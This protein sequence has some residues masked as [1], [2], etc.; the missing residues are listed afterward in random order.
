MFD[1]QIVE[2][3]FSRYDHY[4]LD[5]DCKNQVYLV[6]QSVKSHVYKFSML[7]GCDVHACVQW[8]NISDNLPRLTSISDALED[9][10][11]ALIHMIIRQCTNASEEVKVI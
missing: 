9:H 11:S 10:E 4:A 5:L 2:R 1:V 7:Y 6:K 8:P 3:H